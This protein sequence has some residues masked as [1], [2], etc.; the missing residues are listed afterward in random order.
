VVIF[1]WLEEYFGKMR[2]FEESPIGNSRCDFFVVTDKLTGFEIKSDADSYERLNKQIKDYDAYFDQNYIVVGNQHRKSVVKKVPNHWGI[3]CVRDE[4][5]GFLVDVIR[6]AIQ[7]PK[8]KRDKQMRKLWHN[9]LTSIA[10]KLGTPVYMGKGKT[11]RIK[12][13]I[14]NSKDSDLQQAICEELFERD[15]T[16]YDGEEE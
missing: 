12:G 16:N 9:E 14:K 7:N 8:V 11:T 3:L 2:I 6:R 15:Y 13:I 10:N 1:D 4:E 5:E